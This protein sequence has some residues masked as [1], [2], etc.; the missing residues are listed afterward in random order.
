MVNFNDIDEARRRLGL[1]EAATLKEIKS[2]YRRLSHRY[3]PD[4]KGR[5]GE[6]AM[7]GINQAY[8]LLMDYV[9]NY[10]YSFKEPDVARTSPTEENLRRWWFDG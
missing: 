1:N 3:H 4:K 2:A 7:K 10:E 8:K 6:E 9:N 5:E